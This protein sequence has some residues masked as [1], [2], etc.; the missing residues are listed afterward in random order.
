LLRSGRKGKTS[1]GNQA[2][3]LQKRKKKK[4]TRLYRLAQLFAS[5][6]VYLRGKKKKKNEHDASEGSLRLTLSGEEIEPVLHI[7]SFQ[8]KEGKPSVRLYWVR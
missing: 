3:R 8:W 1:G 2:V 4:R 5:H 6:A 7:S